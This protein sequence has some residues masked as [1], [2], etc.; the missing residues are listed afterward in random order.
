VEATNQRRSGFPIALQEQLLQPGSSVV[1][2]DFDAI[3]GREANTL[4]EAWDRFYV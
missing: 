2:G 3:V 1:T 4:E